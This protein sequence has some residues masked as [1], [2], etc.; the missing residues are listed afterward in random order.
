MRLKA[1][2]GLALPAS[3]VAGA[4]LATII[5]MY[6]QQIFREEIRPY[7]NL[8]PLPATTP[9]I[10]G[11]KLPHAALGLNVWLFEQETAPVFN[12]IQ[13]LKADWVRHQLPWN[14]IEAVAGHYDWQQLDK[15]VAATRQ[16]GVNLLLN[17]VH[18][19]AWA[20]GCQVGMP[21]NPAD[22]AN[23]M[24]QVATRYRGQV[25]AYEIWN[26]AN[27]AQEA[28][29]PLNAGRY[30][31]LLKAGYRAIKAADPQALVVFGG[32]TPTGVKN[33]N[34]AWDEVD[35][36]QQIYAYHNGE[37]R[38]YFDV[39]GAHPGNT[40]NPPDTL[41]PALPGPGPRWLNHPSFYFR[42]IE[43]VRQ[44]MVAAGDQRKQIWLTEFGW[45]SAAQPAPGFEFAAQVSEEQQAQYLERAFDMSRE[46]YPWIGVMFVFQLNFA[47]PSV[48]PDPQDERIA[49]G[50][51]RRD[52][53]KRPAYF[54]LQ[55][56]ARKP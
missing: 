6:P 55:A 8:P 14:E 36:L 42:R 4:L 47:L 22:F 29:K 27:L 37:V 15:V 2:I 43:Q 5:T 28:G 32:L 44:V 11:Q 25:S 39:L 48:T 24:S 30:V 51:I 16:A 33:V 34:V 9:A 31:E 17:P 45:A 18:S 54:A 13:D 20:C 3:L 53:S 19:P 49:W 7:V 1:F 46:N 52:G 41:W 38:N 10:S 12:W 40:L 50:I 23:F 35:F 21:T 26:E 56:Y